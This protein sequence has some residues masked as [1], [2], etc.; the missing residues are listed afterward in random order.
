MH[1]SIE[2]EAINKYLIENLH[3]PLN[4]MKPSFSVYTITLNRGPVIKT[5]V[6]DLRSDKIIVSFNSKKSAFKLKYVFSKY[7][8]YNLT[9]RPTMIQYYQINNVEEVL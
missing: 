3:K 9:K 6:I 1:V 2:A 5:D 8:K 7:E 4:L